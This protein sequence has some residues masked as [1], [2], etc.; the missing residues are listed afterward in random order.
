MSPAGACGGGLARVFLAPRR[1]V[2]CGS[3]P[4]PPP[5]PSGGDAV[6]HLKVRRP[7]SPWAVYLS[8]ADPEAVREGYRERERHM[9]RVLGR[10]WPRL[11]DWGRYTMAVCIHAARKE[12]G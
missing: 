12:A 5:Q 6:S 11:N 1:G 2:F 7:L 4:T 9:R 3:L 8:R 10:E